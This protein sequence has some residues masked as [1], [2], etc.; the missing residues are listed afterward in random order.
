MNA[1]G[2]DRLPEIKDIKTRALMEMIL[3]FAGGVPRDVLVVGCGTGREAGLMARAFGSRVVGIDIDSMFTLDH[4]GSAPAELHLM[5]ARSMTFPDESFD[6]V[7]SFHAL[8]HIPQHRTA[9]AEMSRVLRRGKAYC[10]GTPN[11]ARLVGYLQAAEPLSNKIRY[12][13]KDYGDRLRGRWRNELG[14]HAG[15]TATEL[16]ADCG[17]AFGSAADVSDAYYLSIYARHAALV[18]FLI[19]SGL[20]RWLYPSVYVMGRKATGSS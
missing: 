5:D 10:V 18:R 1:P 20:R 6:L 7:Y 19:R 12:N 17:A 15:F 3:Q 2:T 4:A 13:L 11:S 9:L 14:A 16:A 8:E